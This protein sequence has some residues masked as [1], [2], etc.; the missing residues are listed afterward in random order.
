MSLRRYFY[1]TEKIWVSLMHNIT[2]QLRFLYNFPV[3]EYH[4]LQIT[5]R[6]ANGSI[7]FQ[8]FGR[9]F[10]IALL[11]LMQDIVPSDETPIV[12]SSR[13]KRC[14]SMAVSPLNLCHSVLIYV[15]NVLPV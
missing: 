13:T 8:L 9:N 7:L 10:L 12:V 1:F 4:A 14:R 3:L 11:W 2:I 5:A 6:I 15:L